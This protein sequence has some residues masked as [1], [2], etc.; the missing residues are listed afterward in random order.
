MIYFLCLILIKLQNQSIYICIIEN[1]IVN[2]NI[3]LGGNER[4]HIA[5]ALIGHERRKEIHSR[6]T[7]RNN[8]ALA[9]VK[10]DQIAKL[11]PPIYL[12]VPL[13]CVKDSYLID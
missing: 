5:L 2:V 9:P 7:L 12:V 3:L 1:D 4:V 11:S 8:N 13:P 6:N 10:S